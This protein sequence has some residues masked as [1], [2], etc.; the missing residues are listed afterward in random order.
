MRDIV[1][2]GLV[3]SCCA[4]ALR[5]AWIGILGWTWVSIMNPHRLTY[6]FMFD[7]PVAAAVGGAALLGILFAKEKRN[8][9]IG[10][11]VVWMTLLTIWMSITLIMAYD[12]GS[13]FDMWKKV[14]KVNLM[15]VMTL[16]LM[17]SRL[18]MISFTWV[19]ALSTA[20]FGI[21]GGIFTL[22][23]GGT[24]RVWGPAGSTIEGNN[25]LAVALIVVIPLLRF[26][27]TTVDKTWQK[28]ALTAAMLLCAAAALGS[29]SRG[30][31]LAIGAMAFMLW[32][33][34]P[35]KLLGAIALPFIA[36]ALTA[37]MPE[38]WFS[39]M[40]TISSYEA[41]ASAMGRL[42]AWQMAWNLASHN[43]FGGGFEVYTPML[44]AMYAPNPTDIHAAHSIY[45]QIL[46]EHGFIGLF[47]YL[48]MGFS[49]WRV[50]GWLHKHGNE[51]AETRWCSELGAMSQVAIF[52]FAIG[53]AFLSL[54]YWDLPYDLLALLVAAKFWVLS[55]NWK[56]DL[57]KERWMPQWLIRRIYQQ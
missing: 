46:G 35:R 14:F 55:K 3:I 51:N 23:H 37:F 5:H 33:R 13:S 21:K 26:L 43:L 9:F 45:F 44:F 52:G 39:R 40:D 42:N 56:D 18:R 11:P 49:A 1:L 15:V 41:D 16:V 50:A 57:S 17:N 2:F 47:L 38:H 8:P 34:S 30:A 7:F 24:Y 27:Q 6:G 29:H 36:I 31:L 32:L 48:G 12:F 20:F 19:C 10:P 25:E 53:G 4:M 54:A 28:H 22:L